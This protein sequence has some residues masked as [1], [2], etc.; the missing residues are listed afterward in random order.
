MIFSANKDGLISIFD[1]INDNA[2]FNIILK[3]Q[4]KSKLTVS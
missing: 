4:F 1:I 3:K 2:I